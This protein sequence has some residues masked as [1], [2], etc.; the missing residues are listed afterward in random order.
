MIQ[1]VGLLLSGAVSMMDRQL[2]TGPIGGFPAVAVAL[3]LCPCLSGDV[4]I[5]AIAVIAVNGVIAQRTAFRDG[6]LVDLVLQK[7]GQILFQMVF[8]HI[9][10]VETFLNGGVQ[11]IKVTTVIDDGIVK[12]IDAAIGVSQ[13]N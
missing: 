1:V 3:G 12:N 9:P 13:R 8:P 6:N 10:V 5:P 7:E 2:R 11:T 4:E